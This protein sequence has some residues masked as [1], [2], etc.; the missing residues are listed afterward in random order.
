MEKEF[1][2]NINDG[3]Y[4]VYRSNGYLG[5]FDSNDNQ[6]LPF[7]YDDFEY[8]PYNLQESI[9]VIQNS[10]KGVCSLPYDSIK[11]ARILIPAFYDSI[12]K[13]SI[14]TPYMEYGVSYLFY[15]YRDETVDIWDEKG[16]MIYSDILDEVVFAT[17]SKR[18]TLYLGI[19]KSNKIGIFSYAERQIVIPCE[20]DDVSEPIDGPDGKVFFKISKNGHWGAVEMTKFHSF[21]KQIL[22]VEY[23]DIMITDKYIVVKKNGLYG[24]R[25]L[26]E[27]LTQV[28]FDSV[29]CFLDSCYTDSTDSPMYLVVSKNQQYYLYQESSS[30]VEIPGR[31]KDIY[32]DKCIVYENA[33]LLG[34]IDHQGNV[35]L[36]NVFTSITLVTDEDIYYGEVIKP[37]LLRLNI[38]GRYG[39]YSLLSNKLIPCIYDRISL[40]G[41]SSSLWYAKTK[42]GFSIYNSWL[43]CIV[44]LGYEKYE[45]IEYE[46]DCYIETFF[47]VYLNGKVGLYSDSN[48]CVPC[49]YDSIQIVNLYGYYNLSWW[50]N[51]DV[52][53][54]FW[55][56]VTYNGKKGLINVRGEILIPC[57]CDDINISYDLCVRYKGKVYNGL[58]LSQIDWVISEEQ[59]ED[60]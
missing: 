10:K 3:N 14:L 9:I 25:N 58:T 52:N 4:K 35:L 12:T 38:K 36:Q 27:A 8:E 6:I 54:A 32:S 43:T 47:K 39:M 37:L 56:I 16:A 2:D 48:Q 28:D 15:C 41:E 53:L 40:L 49:T 50:R 33:G 26:E 42:R 34:V 24:I 1:V 21:N 11:P 44:P 60:D 29:D 5:L 13:E 57:V 46:C 45:K 22:P 20:Y 19:K 18:S 51:Q 31:V 23:D 7:L 59:Y 17:E 30:L 55:F